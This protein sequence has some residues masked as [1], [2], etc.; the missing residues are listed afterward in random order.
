MSHVPRIEH[1][2]GDMF[3]ASRAVHLSFLASTIPCL[4]SSGS[5]RFPPRQFNAKSRAVAASI[6]KD[7]AIKNGDRVVLVYP[8]GLE[9]LVAFVA[10]LRA[11]HAPSVDVDEPS[12]SNSRA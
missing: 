8:P 1:I 6:V 7:W 9:F 11:G 4:Q 5:I 10:C 3:I 12:T 2:F